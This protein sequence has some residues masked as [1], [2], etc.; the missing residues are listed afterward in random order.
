VQQEHKKEQL[1]SLPG[2]A[3]PSGK[4]QPAGKLIMTV[5]ENIKVESITVLDLT[6]DDF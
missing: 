6:T 3:F 5:K 2:P 1:S 4:S